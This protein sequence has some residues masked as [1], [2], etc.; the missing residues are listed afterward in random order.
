MQAKAKKAGYIPVRGSAIDCTD[1]D[2]PE[3]IFVPMRG[4]AKGA[5]GDSPA[6]QGGVGIV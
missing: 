2:T 1:T 3:Q 4:S 6:L 5:A